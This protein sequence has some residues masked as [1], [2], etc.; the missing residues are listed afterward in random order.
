MS[1]IKPFFVTGTKIRI[2]LNGK[3]MAFAT[4]FAASVQIMTQTPHV[5]GMYEGSS[6]EPLG[7]NVS[8]SFS[9]V[10]Y[11]KNAQANIGG[12]PP[13]GVAPA[14]GG[15]GVGAWGNTAAGVVGGLAGLGGGL[16]GIGR[17]SAQ[18]G[19]AD[20]ALNPATYNQG[21][22]FDIEV[23]QD[24]PNGDPLGVVRIRSA[25]ISQADFS[26]NKKN[27]GMDRFAFVGLYMDTDSI[28]AQSSGGGQQNQ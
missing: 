6:V 11:V 19:R 26:V 16:P 25:R 17:A 9:I 8:G 21:T 27:P 7:Y 18:D 1:G 23:Y 15:N 14:D 13:N 5:L 3:T 22:T 10:R 12:T 2:V 28:Y 24:N 4:D 20:E